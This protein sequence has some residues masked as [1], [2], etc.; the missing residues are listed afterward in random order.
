MK[1]TRGEY[2]ALRK[3]TVVSENGTRQ[4]VVNAILDDA[5]S[6]TCMNSSVA[7]ELGL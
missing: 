2:V 4:V 7:A 1:E 5:S 3:V 6:K